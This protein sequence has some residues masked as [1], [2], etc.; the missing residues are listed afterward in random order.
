MCTVHSISGICNT[1]CC[2]TFPSQIGKDGKFR[3]LR[4]STEDSLALCKDF[5]NNPLISVI[6]QIYTQT[7][8]SDKFICWH[9][10][11]Q[12][13]G[14]SVSRWHTSQHY[15]GLIWL[16]EEQNYTINKESWTSVV[17]TSPENGNCWRRGGRG[18][19]WRSCTLLPRVLVHTVSIGNLTRIFSKLSSLKTGRHF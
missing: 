17:L 14:V 13:I 16:I 18:G 4:Q 7:K 8:L 5:G 1:C 10:T 6:R 15:P 19:G 11:D 12:N 2:T 3:T 9:K